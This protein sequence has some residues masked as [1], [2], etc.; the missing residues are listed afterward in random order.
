MPNYIMNHY[1][2]FE[3]FKI[4]LK[5]KQLFLWDAATLQ[6]KQ[7]KK[8]MQWMIESIAP[9]L[10][11]KLSQTQANEIVETYN[12]NPAV[13]FTASFCANHNEA[14]MWEKYGDRGKGICITFDNREYT[15]Q[16]GVFD[17]TSLPVFSLAKVG[18]VKKDYSSEIAKKVIDDCI[19]SFGDEDTYNLH[20][21]IFIELIKIGILIKGYEEFH[22][23][24][25]YR[26]IHWNPV[27]FRSEDRDRLRSKTYTNPLPKEFEYYF[28]AEKIIHSDENSEGVVTHKA[29]T[30]FRYQEAMP[31]VS[32]TLGRECSPQAI[33]EI[34]SLLIEHD[35]DP[36]TIEIKK[37]GS[38][39]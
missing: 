35:F 18:Y 9:Y 15:P 37:A 19:N 25:E 20:S 34:K 13:Y 1:T 23:E 12:K 39:F 4:I 38:L 6:D 31:I 7:D 21:L 16:Q 26:L 17:L 2:S 29:V 27:S 8:E 36:V 11:E 22:Q 24:Q 10:A 30:P 3:T 28:L 14:I 5:Q 33:D 32:I